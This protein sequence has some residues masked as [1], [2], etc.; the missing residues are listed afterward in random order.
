[1]G[2]PYDAETTCTGGN[3]VQS[4]ANAVRRRVQRGLS[5]IEIVVAVTILSGALFTLGVLIPRCVRNMHDKSYQMLAIQMAERILEGARGLDA[6]D[7]PSRTWSTVDAVADHPSLPAHA[8]SPRRQFPPDPYPADG[9]TPKSVTLQS[10]GQ[11]VTVEYRFTVSVEPLPS[12][13]RRVTVTVR[14][15]EPESSSATSDRT[16][17]LASEMGT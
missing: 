12:G 2:R 6:S 9:F 10:N 3:F 13:S 15:R 1:M 14:W 7:V 16:F 5:L 11:P 8:A 17:T 4:E